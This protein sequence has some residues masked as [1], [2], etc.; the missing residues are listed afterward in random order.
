M[1][2]IMGSE[3]FN[4]ENKTEKK[5]DFKTLTFVTYTW[6]VGRSDSTPHRNFINISKCICL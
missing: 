4:P 1:W 3:G 6:K 5:K 2:R